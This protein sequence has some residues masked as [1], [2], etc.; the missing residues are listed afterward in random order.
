M[1]LDGSE[2]FWQRS[3][4]LHDNVGGIIRRTS[5]GSLPVDRCIFVSLPF[6]LI[7]EKLDIENHFGLELGKM[8]VPCND[9]KN[10]NKNTINN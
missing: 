9:N 2:F 5:P 8:D 3:S 4:R 6:Y 7:K 10:K 1:L